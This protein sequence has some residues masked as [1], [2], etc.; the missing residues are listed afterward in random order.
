VASFINAIP[1]L[2]VIEGGWVFNKHDHG[3]ESYS[4]IARNY[5]P[6]WHGWKIIDAVKAKIGPQPQ[7]NKR[8]ADMWRKLLDR[9]L[10]ADTKLREMV[11]DFYEANFWRP[12]YNSIAPQVVSN[13]L[14]EKHVHF[15]NYRKPARWIQRA[16]G[17][18]PDGLIG[19][20]SINAIN[21]AKDPKVLRDRAESFA[22]AL[23]RRIA[24]KDPTQKEFL[25]GWLARS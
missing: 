20:I 12:E 18:K 8:Q 14:F 4:G 9:I 3:G 21:T 19:P 25:S 10:L 7:G 13:W 5:W 6:Q 22:E 24:Q 15:G 23:Y 11:M 2:M 1:S 16:A 17:V